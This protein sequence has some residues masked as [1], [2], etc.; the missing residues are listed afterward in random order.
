[1]ETMNLD[2]EKDLQ[3]A[4]TPQTRR[5]S[6][7][8]LL[9]KSLQ[10]AAHPADCRHTY[11]L[12]K[13]IYDAA[14]AFGVRYNGESVL[15]HGDLSILSMHATK[16]FNTIEGGAIIC[17]DTK[18][19]KRIDYLRKNFGF[20]DEVTVVAPGIN[21][22]M[23]PTYRPHSACFGYNLLISE[24]AKRRIVDPVVLSR[25]SRRR[26]SESQFSRSHQMLPETMDI[27]LF[28]LSREYSLTRDG[29]YQSL[30][31][32]GMHARRYFLPSH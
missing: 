18:T 5:E 25:L 15:L 20:A 27:F 9:W 21:G 22:K 6:C 10:R 31:Q 26:A 17:G 19:K 24:I 11:G 1:M 28:W 13:A 2:P 12:K 16:V 29:L 23:N 4:I 14:H 30:R 8:S 32:A 3:A 7:R